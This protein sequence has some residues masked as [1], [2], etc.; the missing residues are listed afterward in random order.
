MLNFD[1]DNDEYDTE[2]IRANELVE[3]A[4]KLRKQNNIKGAISLYQKSLG[5]YLNS[6]AYMKLAEI[7]NNIVS[8]VKKESEMLPIMER[9]RRTINEIE[10]LDLLEEL[11]NLKLAQANLTYKS[12]NYL[13]AGNLFIDVAEL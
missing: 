5:I 9:L 6:G 10:K 11:A 2:L 12:S 13:D 7:F 4:S 8:L 1:Y 3:N